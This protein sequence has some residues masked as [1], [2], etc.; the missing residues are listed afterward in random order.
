MN[1]S[2]LSLATQYFGQHSVAIIP[3]L[4]QKS[5]SGLSATQM[6]AGDWTALGLSYG[7]AREL[8]VLA[9]IVRRWRGYPPILP[10]RLPYLFGLFWRTGSLDDRG[11]IARWQ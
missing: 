10:F 6:T 1:E 9:E 7:Y 8:L 4:R 3:L 5:L 2:L 11:Y